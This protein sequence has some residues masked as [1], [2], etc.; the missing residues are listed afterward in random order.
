MKRLIRVLAFT[1]VFAGITSSAF[2]QTFHLVNAG[3]GLCLDGFEA[4][5]GSSVHYPYTYTC[6]SQNTYQQWL[7]TKTNVGT[8]YCNYQT[9]H[10]LVFASDRFQSPYLGVFDPSPP[11]EQWSYNQRLNNIYTGLCLDGYNNGTL[12]SRVY[13]DICDSGDGYQTWV[14]SFP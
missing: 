9:G 5:D 13:M 1:A 14:K 8:M 7:E 11:Y 6:S 2:A 3:S 4:N 10:C 12:G